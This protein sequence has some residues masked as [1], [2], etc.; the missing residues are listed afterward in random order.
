MLNDEKLLAR[1]L[2]RL[3]EIDG[4]AGEAVMKAL[5]DVAPDLGRY[6]IGFAFGEIYMRPQLDLRQRELVTLAALAAQGG[7][8]KQVIMRHDDLAGVTC[9]YFFSA[10]NQRNIP[11]FGT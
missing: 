11:F 1:G 2:A 10:N 7:C 9:S 6:I 8:E 5:A 4:E 3:N